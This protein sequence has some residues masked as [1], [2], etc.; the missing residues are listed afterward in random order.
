MVDGR[1]DNGGERDG[2]AGPDVETGPDE[3]GAA[4]PLVAAERST[5]TPHRT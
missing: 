4:T 5:S 3:L 1:D 2:E